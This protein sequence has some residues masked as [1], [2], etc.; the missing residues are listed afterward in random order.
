[1]TQTPTLLA[2]LLGRRGLDR[3]GTFRPAY[4]QAARAVD[5]RLARGVDSPTLL[6]RPGGEPGR[7]YPVFEH[8]WDALATRSTPL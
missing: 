5:P 3:Y 2:V 8:V 7:R 4:E 6:I 1:M